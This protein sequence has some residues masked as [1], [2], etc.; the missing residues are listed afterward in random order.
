[1]FKKSFNEKVRNAVQVCLRKHHSSSNITAEQARNP[2]FLRSIINRDEGYA[3]FKNVCSSSSY[4]KKKRQTVVSMVRQIGKCSFFVTLSAA[5][6]KWPE[7]LVT[8]TKLLR[9]KNITVEEA[10]NLSFEE[11]TYLIKTD[12]V[13]CMRHFDHKYRELLNVILKRKGGAFGERKLT[14]YL[15]RLEFQMRDSPHSHGLY[16]VKI[17]QNL[18]KMMNLLSLCVVL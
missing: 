6:N 4:W 5:E 1:M 12:P 14:E 17:L 15:S 8:L 18:S 11:K 10:E 9:R 3:V 2:Q 7:L 16:W 13:T